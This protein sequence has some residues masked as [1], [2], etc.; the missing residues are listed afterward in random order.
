MKQT[1][2]GTPNEPLLGELEGRRQVGD[3]GRRR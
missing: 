2:A 3:P 1:G